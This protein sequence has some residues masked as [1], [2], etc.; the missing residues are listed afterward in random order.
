M[1][2]NGIE[3]PSPMCHRRLC[4]RRRAWRR[5]S[6]RPATA[7]ASAR[8]SR[9]LAFCRS[10]VTWRPG[11]SRAG[12]AAAVRR[13]DRRPS[14]R[15]A[16]AEL[17]R[18]GAQHVAG[19]ASGGMPSAPVM[20]M[21]GRQVRLSTSLVR[22][23][24]VHRGIRGEEGNLSKTRCRA[25]AA[26]AGL[27]QAFGRD[28]DMQRREPDPAG[29]RPEARRAAGGIRK[30]DGTMPEASPR[31][32]APAPDGRLPAEAAQRGGRPSWS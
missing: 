17:H 14:R 25:P 20:D 21:A 29:L 5:R 28:L 1:P 30:L 3:P 18:G 26:S 10:S 27:R 8:S 6:P 16:Q 31:V 22:S 13:R 9:C 2:M 12:L 4:R 7:S 19:D 15:Q 32:H 24:V 23:G 11:G